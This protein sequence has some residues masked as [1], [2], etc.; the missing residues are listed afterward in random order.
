[1]DTQPG[2]RRVAFA[3]YVIGRDCNTWMRE[4]NLRVTLQI[5]R[6]RLLRFKFGQRYLPRLAGMFARLNVIEQRDDFRIAHPFQ[7][8]WRGGGRQNSRPRVQISDHK[9]ERN[10]KIQTLQE[11][12]SHDLKY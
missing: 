2:N 9:S 10:P 4:R 11:N 12:F 6:D 8:V 1:M 7:D 3:A 5:P